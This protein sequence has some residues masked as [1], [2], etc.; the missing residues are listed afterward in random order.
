[1]P[2][3]FLDESSDQIVCHRAQADTRA[4]VELEPGHRLKNSVSKIVPG[5]PE[6]LQP[7]PAARVRSSNCG[8]YLSGT[9]CQIRTRT[10]PTTQAPSIF[11]VS[12]E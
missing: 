3:K 4:K 5:S 9:R 2:T 6:L 1:M 10:V 12:E 7:Y 8:S 11:P